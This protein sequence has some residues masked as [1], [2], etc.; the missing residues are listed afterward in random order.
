MSLSGRRQGR[1]DDRVRQVSRPLHS[2][3]TLV[4]AGMPEDSAM[5][6]NREQ[7]PTSILRVVLACLTEV[8]A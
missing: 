3:R 5:A 8:D 2:A 4:S 6:G 1:E 7:H